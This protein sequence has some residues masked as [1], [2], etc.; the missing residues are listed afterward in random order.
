MKAGKI[1]ISMMVVSMA[2]HSCKNEN[3]IVEPIT[4]EFRKDGDLQLFAS[5]NDSLR[6]AFNIEIADDEY[7]RQRGLMDRHSMEDDQAMLFIFPGSNLRGFY[8]KSTYIPLDII[9]IGSDQ[10]IVSFQKNAQPLDEKSLPS[11]V[12]AQYVLEI[13]GGLADQMGLKVGDSIA[14]QRQ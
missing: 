5:E 14:F 9:F 1:L 13:K 10:K 7:E 4:V 8:M 6:A 11:N 3:K 12:P 2:L